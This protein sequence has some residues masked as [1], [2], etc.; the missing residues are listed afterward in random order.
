MNARAMHRLLRGLPN[1]VRQITTTGTTQLFGD[2]LHMAIIALNVAGGCTVSFPRTTGSGLC[3]WIVVLK[4]STTGY[5]LDCDPT[6]D[7]FFGGISVNLSGSTSTDFAS[8]T[9]SNNII[10]LNGTTTGG[11]Q[12]GDTLQFIDLAAG[13]WAVSGDIIGTGSIATP[14]S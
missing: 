10:T 7:G 1:D 5:V 14:F 6:T 2:D 11:A 12:I 9:S 8:G 4:V 3:F 13:T